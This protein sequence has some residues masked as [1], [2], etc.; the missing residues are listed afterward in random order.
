MLGDL[1][2]QYYRNGYNCSQC[3]I[4]AVE[5][6]YKIS[7]GEMPLN[8]T[9][10]VCGGFGIGNICCC[11]VGAIFSLGALFDDEN[12]IKR[13]RMQLIME[14]K[15]RFRDISCCKLKMNY[16]RN[17]EC[18]III[19]DTCDMFERLVDESLCNK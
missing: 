18:D 3:I 13:L 17:K 19:K 1:A 7:F 6:K 15:E 9:R 14:F 5:T 4:K 2:I 12:E 10:G 11:L 8:M 16:A